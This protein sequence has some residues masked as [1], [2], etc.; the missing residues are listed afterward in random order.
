[1]QPIIQISGLSK[2]YATGF[3]AL[4]NINLEIRRGEIFALLGPNGAG[5]TTLIGIVCGT[6]NPSKGTVRVDG[7]DNV[8][9]FRAAREMIGPVPP[10]RRSVGRPVKA[11]TAIRSIVGLI[12]VVNRAGKSV[13]IPQAAAVRR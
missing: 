9:D 4:R 3:D 11:I 12:P 13:S 8:T 1:M 5:K 2:T 7:H 10:I 6:I